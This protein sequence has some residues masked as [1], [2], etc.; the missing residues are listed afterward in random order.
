MERIHVD[1]EGAPYDVLVGEDLLARAGPLLAPLARDGR[2]LVV[3]DTHV[4][5]HVLPHLEA[6]LA[7]FAI[8]LETHILPAGE[9]SKSWGE[10]EGLIDW[11]LA[12]HV[13]R[14]DHIIALGGGVVGDITG[15]AAHI[16]KRGCQFVQIPTTLL[17]QVDS[18]VGGKT[19]INSAA[20]KNLVGA[21]HQPALVLI[22]PVV[23]DTLPRREL[24]AGYAEV[25][26]YGL[27]DSAEFFAWCEASLDAFMAGD[28]DARRHAIA[29][30]V[31][32]KARIVAADE[33]ELNGIRALLNLGHTFG[34][35]LEAETGYSDRLLHGEGVAAGMAL[36]FRYSVRRGHCP[37]TDA[38]RVAGH[39]Q[40]AGLPTTLR[41]AHVDAT[42]ARLVEHMLHDKK[43]SGGT[44]P[45]LLA[46]GIG[47]TFLARD[48]DLADVAAFLDEERNR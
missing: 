37:A 30:S 15:F 3:T 36:A 13:E 45:F 27:I 44:L 7:G 8:A 19:A 23:L 42:G 21:F 31:A 18:S 14:S 16:V 40:Q 12:R 11:L 4:A 22:D 29:R 2:L 34:H 38:D 10:L 33:K 32:A 46:N 39:L 28:K 17:A 26:K 48:V 24:G 25:V 43:K 6:T 41:A 20:G 35:A 1:L 47:K 9:G 5:T